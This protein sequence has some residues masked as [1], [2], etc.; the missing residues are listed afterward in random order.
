MREYGDGSGVMGNDY[1]WRFFSLPNA[2]SAGFVPQ[3]EIIDW[4]GRNGKWVLMDSA[5]NADGHLLPEYKMAVTTPCDTCFQLGSNQR[6]GMLFVSYKRGTRGFDSSLK[7]EYKQKVYVRL[8]GNSQYG[9]Y[10]SGTD[11]YA[12]LGV[13]QSID[14]TAVRLAAAESNPN[15]TRTQPQ[16]YPNPITLT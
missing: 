12:Y 2:W 6:G 7:A 16:P 4:G 10:D 9:R 14:Y 3:S 5:M 1:R 8:L 13:G 11:K 15:P